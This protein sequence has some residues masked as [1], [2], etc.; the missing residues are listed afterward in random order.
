M[1]FAL[2]SPPLIKVS[3]VPWRKTCAQFGQQTDTRPDNQRLSFTGKAHG[4]A[5]VFRRTQLRSGYWPLRERESMSFNHYLYV[6]DNPSE[7]PGEAGWN[8]PLLSSRSGLT[9]ELSDYGG[10][11]YDLCVRCSP[12][13]RWRRW[14]QDRIA[15]PC[16]RAVSPNP[17]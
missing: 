8:A 5:H 4:E 6:N 13:G 16:G 15:P 14:M 7:A 12:D 17:L 11:R 1:G 3:A 2:S 9:T 10:R